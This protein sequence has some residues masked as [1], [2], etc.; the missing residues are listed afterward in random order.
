MKSDGNDTDAS[1]DEE[2][3]SKKTKTKRTAIIKL[4]DDDKMEGGKEE[5]EGFLMEGTSMFA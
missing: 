3:P 5:S 4:E 1:N 2:S